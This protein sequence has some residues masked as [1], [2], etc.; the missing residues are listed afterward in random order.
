MENAEQESPEPKAESE[1]RQA[2]RLNKLLG[3][4]LE[5]EENRI[6]VRLFIID[7]SAT[8]FRAT[9]QFALPLDCELKV[10]IVLQAQTPPLEGVARIVWSKE[11]PM[12]GLFQFGFEFLTLDESQRERLESF[13]ESE[14]QQAQKQPTQ[15][16][17]LGRPWTMI[18]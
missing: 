10:E 14:R 4:R 11:M 8:G 2:Y 15:A 13:I 1:R 6:D 9:N 12:S 16:T 18:R 17:D 5:H 7:I 3:A